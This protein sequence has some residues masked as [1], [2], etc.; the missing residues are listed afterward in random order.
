MPPLPE[1]RESHAHAYAQQKFPPARRAHADPDEAS[2]RPSDMAPTANHLSRPEPRSLPSSI[3]RKRLALDRRLRQIDRETSA[4]NNPRPAS[5]PSRASVAAPR[6]KM[7]EC[8]RRDRAP[9]RRSRQT[10]R[11][12]FRSSHSPLRP[13]DLPLLLRWEYQREVLWRGRPPPR[14]VRKFRTIQKLWAAGL[15]S[16][17]RLPSSGATIADWR[18]QKA[19]SR[20]HRQHRSRTYR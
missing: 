15:G 20:K 18:R 9:A 5:L 6:G 19:E 16:A 7:C 11:R 4:A 8:V 13:P 14:R 12:R 17:A 3:A 1:S 10:P 2:A